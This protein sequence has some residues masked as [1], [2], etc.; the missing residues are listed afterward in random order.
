MKHVSYLFLFLAIPFLIAACVREDGHVP[1]TL[2]TATEESDGTGAF[3]ENIGTFD[4][5]IGSDAISDDGSEYGAL[6]EIVDA[7]GFPI[8]F[9]MLDGM[10]LTKII[11][12]EEC[13]ER[14]LLNNKDN[15]TIKD[16]TWQISGNVLIISGNWEESFQVD[17]DAG[18]ATS[19]SN[20]KVYRLV[21]YSEDGATQ[22]YVE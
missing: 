6:Q 15:P 2:I 4:D 8:M 10:E 19:L 5:T 12:Y 13:A 21:V 16:L 1:D 11:L 22:F 18:T 14:Q 7:Y 20:R 9:N 3:S 17:I